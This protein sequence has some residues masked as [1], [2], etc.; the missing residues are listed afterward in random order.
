MTRLP[1]WMKL[2]ALCVACMVLMAGVLAFYADSQMRSR[3]KSDVLAMQERNLIVAAQSLAVRVDGVVLGVN[4]D[5]TISRVTFAAWPEFATEATPDHTFIDGVG[6]L[7]GETATIFAYDPAERD[8]IRR[9]TNIVKPDGQRAVGTYLGEGSA[10]YDPIMSGEAYLGTANILGISYETLYMPIFS[11]D[12]TVARSENGVAGI[13]YVGVK[14]AALK[15]AIAALERGLTIAAVLIVLVAAALAGFACWAMLRPLRTAVSQMR[16][17]ADGETIDVAVTRKDE[18]GE[19]QSALAE[20]A[21]TAEVAFRQAQMMEQSDAAVMTADPTNDM[22][23]GYANPAGER[24]FADL[25]QRSSTGAAT[26]QGAMI[27]AFFENPSEMRRLLAD[28]AHLP[29]DARIEFGGEI[30]DLKASALHNRDGSYAGPMLHWTLATSQERLASQFETDIGALL[31][32]VGTA[33]AT[34]TDRTGLLEEAS[35]SSRMDSDETAKVAIEASESVQ[36]VAAAVEELDQSFAEIARRIAENAE[37]AR[38]ASE[39]TTEASSSGAALEEAG[40]RITEVISLIADVAAQ[41]NLLALNATIEAS[42]AGEAGRG[43]AVVASEVKE[44]AQRAANATAE[45]TTEVE[46][47]NAAGGALLKAVENVR[48]AIGSVDE[49]SSTVAAAVEQQQATTS[50]ISRA[51]HGVASSARRV[52]DLAAKQKDSSNH[53]GQAAGEVGGITKG[54]RDTGRDLGERAASFLRALRQAA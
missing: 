10:A 37:M 4:A 51:V 50:E 8:F 13:L 53:T 27:D 39:A 32:Q 19:M 34:L 33:L 31:D 5:D 2:A 42:R 47:V 41:T 18:L 16:Q 28:P 38:R 1:V 14:D 17:L 11:D 46:R 45:V 48:G 7:T 3:I 24:L 43:F 23:V 26:L 12:P 25:S 20:L 49:I 22:R 21:A 6:M 36:A 35:N 44:L 29:H 54:L 9:T 15:A 30:L 52:Q 40:K